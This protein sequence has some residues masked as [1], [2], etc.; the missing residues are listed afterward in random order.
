MYRRDADTSQGHVKVF[1]VAPD[2]S[3]TEV[4]EALSNHLLE[5]TAGR[6]RML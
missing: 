5:P 2:W 4:M 3:L 6:L 1:H